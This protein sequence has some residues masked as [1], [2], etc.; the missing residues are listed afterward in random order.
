MRITR[1]PDHFRIDLEEGPVLAAPGDGRPGAGAEPD[2]RDTVQAAA[3]GA[4]GVDGFRRS[5]RRNSN[6]SAAGRAGDRRAVIVAQPLRAMNGGA[7][8]RAGGRAVVDLR[9]LCTPKKLRAVSIG[10]MPGCH[11]A[12]HRKTQHDEAEEARADAALKQHRR[13]Q[14][15]QQNLERQLAVGGS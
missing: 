3:R 14:Q 1:D 2:D 12:G 15:R 9:H 8:D 13:G 5:A 10:A 7:V 11:S 4:R 6:R